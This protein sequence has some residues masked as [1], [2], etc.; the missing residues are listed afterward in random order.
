MSRQRIPRAPLDATS[1]TPSIIH[2]PQ[3][4]NANE[5][6]W[7]E[8]IGSSFADAELTELWPVMLKYFDGK[9]ALD[10][11]ALREGLKRK[12]VAAVLARLR[13]GGWLLTVRHW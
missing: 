11:I 9:H 1:L 3:R 7:I 13:E 8:Y 2:S 6:R 4:A 10:E 5:S 12:R